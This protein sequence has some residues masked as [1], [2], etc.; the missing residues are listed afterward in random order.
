MNIQFRDDRQMRALTSLS[1]SQFEILLDVFTMVFL[2]IQ[3][4][5]Y[6][7]GLAS[8][9]RHR[10]PGGGRKGALPTMHDKLLF[11]LYY[12]KV[13]PTFDVLGSQFG[14][15]RS[16]ANENLYK[17]LPVLYQALVYLEVMPHREFATAAE[18]REALEGLDTIVVDVTERNHRRPQDKQA[19]REHY[20]GKKT[21]YP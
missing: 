15:A 2:Q 17:L 5:T 20:S 21:T 8:G 16:K 10:R 3:Q 7:D 11:V 1:L 18:L 13:Y 19:Q 9:S 12:F 14:M 6:Q 4:Q